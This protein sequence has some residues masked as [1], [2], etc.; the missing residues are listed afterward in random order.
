MTVSVIIATFNRAGLLVRCLE[1]LARQHFEHGDEVIVVDNGSTDDTFAAIE[2]ARRRIPAVLRHL[3]EPTPGKSI[4]VDRALQVATGDIL[5]FTDDDVEVDEGWLSAIR[6]V[7]NDADI[8]LMGGPVAPRW[9]SKPPLWLQRVS[10]R[11]G[12]LAA[13]LAILDYGPATVDVGSR[14]VIGANLAIRREVFRA[15]G[16]FA[17]N[18]GKLRGTL[19]SGEDHELCRR[20]QA[21][22][23]RAVYCP[24]ARV[25]HWVPAARMRI[26][27][28]ASWFFWSGIT[29]ARLDAGRTGGRTLVGI[30][31]Y[32]IKR[33]ATSAGAVLGA[34]L[35]GQLTALVERLA[36]VAF[37]AGYATQA[38]R[39]TSARRSA[40]VAGAQR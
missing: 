24:A 28:Y 29:H 16:G 4:A 35:T 27:Y 2:A 32:I 30:P 15:V 36:D 39:M 33:A 38:V 25:R 11:Y 9:E 13:P 7:M 8:A 14:T 37:A 19:L 6:T 31:L 5:A 18:L 23:L 1:H 34:A 20:V 21:M 22:S 40:L 10:D 3:Y 17:A 12:A 26:G